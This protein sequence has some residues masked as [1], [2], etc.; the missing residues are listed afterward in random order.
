MNWKYSYQGLLP[1]NCRYL[2][3]TLD[4][5]LFFI[6]QPRWKN[7][8]YQSHIFYKRLF[9]VIKKS[10]LLSSLMIDNTV[11]GPLC[12]QLPPF[13]CSLIFPLQCHYLLP[14]LLFLFRLS[15]TLSSWKLGVRL[16]CTSLCGAESL[17]AVLPSF[18]ESFASPLLPFI[19]LFF[20]S[21]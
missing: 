18:P 16:C 2:K 9:K 5:T 6:S 4:V 7:I 11:S 3:L 8:L 19:L 1:Q 12:R 13:F 21:C 20:C 17:A 15:E 10:H 14:Y